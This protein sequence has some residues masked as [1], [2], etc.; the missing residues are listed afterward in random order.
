M[1]KKKE[2]INLSS[3]SMGIEINSS[4]VGLCHFLLLSWVICARV[5]ENKSISV[6]NRIVEEA[7]NF[8]IFAFLRDVILN[9]SRFH[10]HVFNV[11]RHL[12][13]LCIFVKNFIVSCSEEVCII[14]TYI[15]IDLYIDK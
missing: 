13:T 11:E 3:Y 2:N 1:P 5:L 8:D 4:P 6:E 7:L 12:D 9:N 15:Y 14:S 10:E